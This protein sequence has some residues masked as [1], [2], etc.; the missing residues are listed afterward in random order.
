MKAVAS[1]AGVSVAAVSKVLNNGYGVSADM[2]D[3]VLRSV[4]K[5]GYR[6]SFAARGMRG[7][8]DTIGVL[9]VDMRNPFL[10]GLTEGIKSDLA[11][12]G[13]VMMM[14]VGEAEMSI[15]SSLI[16][17]MID[18]RM[19]G[20]I[21]VAPCLT[22]DILSDYASQIPTVVIG[23]HDPEAEGF[24]TVNSDDCA[25]AQLAVEHLI[26][27]GHEDIWMLTAPLRPGG[28]EVFHMRER[29]YRLAMEQ[30]GLADR[31]H[32]I[33]SD[34]SLGDNPDELVALLD[35]IPRPGAVFCWSDIH[36]IPL[37][38]MARERGLR[39]PRD[40]AIVGYDNTPTAALP[41][42]GLTS[43]EQH[44]DQLG[45]QAAATMLRRVAEGSHGKHVL[46]QPNLVPRASS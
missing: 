2:R 21:L 15:E 28:K 5:L 14:S 10:A 22:T 18:M 40:L 19:D 16:D 45:R 24:D 31:M 26:A 9:L 44:A 3:R 17:A 32:V 23:H 11:S 12:E 27:R 8:T 38:T 4:E 30:A 42:I 39:V 36:A 6:P 35:D 25:G 46:I 13:K 1:D 7:A 20:V 34:T 41:P 43:V 33:R 37:L 29:G